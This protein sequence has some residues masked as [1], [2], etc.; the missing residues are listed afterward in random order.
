MIKKKEFNQKIDELKEK[1]DD[2]TSAKL[3]EDL[4]GFKSIYSGLYDEYKALEEEKQKLLQDKEELLKVNGS[5]YQQI[6]FEKKE[7]NKENAIGT[8]KNEEE[9]LT[10]DDL[11]DKNGNFIV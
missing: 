6:G 11:I 8:T 5:L 1:L 7:E 2:T 4:L 3:S 10:V 9:K